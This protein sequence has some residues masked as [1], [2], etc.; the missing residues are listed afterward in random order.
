MNTK[1]VACSHIGC[2]LFLYSLSPSAS[3]PLCLSACPPGSPTPTAKSSIFHTF[4]RTLPRISR[5][6]PPFAAFPTAK[7]STFCTFAR[8]SPHVSCRKP[9]FAA[10]PTAK[11]STFRTFARTSPRISHRNPPFAAFPIAKSSLFRTFARTSPLAKVSHGGDRC[12]FGPG[13]PLSRTSLGKNVGINPKRESKGDISLADFNS[14][15]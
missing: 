14:L 8:T 9:P 4:A 6:N 11:S 10:F 15:R 5:R 2:T 1:K 7:S 13:G 3:L 12:G